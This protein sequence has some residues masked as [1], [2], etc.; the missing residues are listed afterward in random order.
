MP[1]AALVLFVSRCLYRELSCRLVQPCGEG[2]T[3]SRQIFFYFIYFF[4]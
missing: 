3:Y 2:V 4:L 1:L